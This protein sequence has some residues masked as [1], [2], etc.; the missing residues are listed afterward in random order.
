[1]PMRKL[2]SYET[3]GFFSCALEATSLIKY[4]NHIFGYYGSLD[5]AIPG[6]LEHR[7]VLIRGEIAINAQEVNLAKVF[8][9][10]LFVVF[11]MRWS[12]LADVQLVRQ[13]RQSSPSQRRCTPT[14]IAVSK[15][16]LP[17]PERR[18]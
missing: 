7:V 9:N 15:G 6:T 17:E 4:L 1:M 11:G 5:Q 8:R 12:S 16:E 13:R 2:Y 18:A 10:G 3:C 14:Y